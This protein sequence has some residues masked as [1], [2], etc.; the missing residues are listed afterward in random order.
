MFCDMR[1]DFPLYHLYAC[2]RYNLY[3]LLFLD[4]NLANHAIND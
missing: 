2:L 1:N 3:C 4:M